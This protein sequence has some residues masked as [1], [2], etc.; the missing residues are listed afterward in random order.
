MDAG[1]AYPPDRGEFTAGNPLNTWNPPRGS[2]IGDIAGGVKI[3][4]DFLELLM[5]SSS[6]GIEITQKEFPCSA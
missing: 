1:G 2:A 6:W 5:T 3:G 4:G